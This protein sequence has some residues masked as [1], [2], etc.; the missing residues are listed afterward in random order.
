MTV[1]VSLSSAGDDL[2]ICRPLGSTFSSAEFTCSVVETP[3]GGVPPLDSA[4]RNAPLYSGI[5]LIDPS[6]SALR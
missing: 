1:R 5:M 4:A 2:R 6:L 3:A